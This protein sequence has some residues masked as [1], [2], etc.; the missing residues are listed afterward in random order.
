MA[1]S[2]MTKSLECR[3]TR[4]KYNNNGSCGYQ[5]RVLIDQNGECQMM[6][7]GFGGPPGPHGESSED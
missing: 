2:N 3:C 1:H 6:E 4:C 7:T 5:G